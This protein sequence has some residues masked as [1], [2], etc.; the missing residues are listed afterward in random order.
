MKAPTAVVEA[1]QWEKDKW[2]SWRSSEEWATDATKKLNHSHWTGEQVNNQTCTSL[3]TGDK[4]NKKSSKRNPDNLC[5][6]S[7]SNFSMHVPP[8]TRE[9]RFHNCIPNACPI[10]SKYLLETWARYYLY[11]IGFLTVTGCLC[12]TRFQWKLNL[13]IWCSGV[14][15]M[16][17]FDRNRCHLG[18]VDFWDDKDLLGSEFRDHLDHGRSNEP[19]NFCPEWSHQFIW[20]TMIWVISEH[21]SSF[22][23]SQRTHS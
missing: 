1:T 2:A 4:D 17:C 9:S 11:E 23:S 15:P 22:R 19:M 16:N 7:V 20:S 13:W 14:W 12:T 8:N 18:Y 6:G 21:L 5:Q 10:H 3:Y